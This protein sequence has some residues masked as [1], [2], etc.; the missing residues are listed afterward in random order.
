MPCTR[1]M[2]V[3]LRTDFQGHMTEYAKKQASGDTM[4]PEGG[5]E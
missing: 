3:S 5:G 2:T 1:G 4:T